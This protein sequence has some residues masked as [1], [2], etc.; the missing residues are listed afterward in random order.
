MEDRTLDFSPTFCS[1]PFNHR[2]IGPAG[3]EKPC[4]RFLRPLIN[5]DDYEGTLKELQHYKLTGKRHPGCRKCYE[6]EDAGRTRSLRQIY[7]FVTGFK[8]T[9]LGIGFEKAFL[10]Y[11]IDPAKTEKREAYII[12]ETGFNFTYGSFDRFK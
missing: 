8:E 5:Y 6:E 2:F 3:E 12:N 10:H 4:S 7:N 11:T 1:L 9:E